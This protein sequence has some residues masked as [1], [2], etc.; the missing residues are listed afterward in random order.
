VVYPNNAVAGFKQ[1]KEAGFD[2]TIFGGDSFEAKEVMDAVGS[3]GVLYVTP[4]ANNP[5]EFQ[6]K[7]KQVHSGNIN[8]LTPLYYDALYI[9]KEAIERADSLD[10]EAIKD[11]LIET[12]YKGITFPLVEFN[13]NREIKEAAFRVNVIKNHQSEIYAD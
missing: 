3:D 11:S 4:K 6:T 9:I 5:E 10:G 12:H 1:L 8:F 7:V 2:K 13:D